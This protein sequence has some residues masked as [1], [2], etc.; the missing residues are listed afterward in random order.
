MVVAICSSI[1]KTTHLCQMC[2]FKI[3]YHS[4]IETIRGG[5]VGHVEALLPILLETAPDETGIVLLD[6]F[7][8]VV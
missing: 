7:P 6:P 2:D 1:I 3:H 8:Y 4:N 5:C